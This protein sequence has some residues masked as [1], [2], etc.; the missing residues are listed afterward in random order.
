MQP[1]DVRNT[2]SDGRLEYVSNQGLGRTT[3]HLAL[4][5]GGVALPCTPPWRHEDPSSRGTA[6]GCGI[7]PF[8]GHIPES[9]GP[10][11]H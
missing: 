1:W 5:G 9:L 11:H 8:R 4:A 7:C 3:Q 6:S 2:L 10:R